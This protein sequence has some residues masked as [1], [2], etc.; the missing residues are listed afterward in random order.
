[1]KTSSKKK[2]IK[3]ILQ[4]LLIVVLCMVLI[5]GVCCYFLFS[6]IIS[7]VAEIEAQLESKI[8]NVE[9][10]TIYDRNGIVIGEVGMESREIV[11][12]EQ[13]PQVTIDAFLAIEDSRYFSHNGF[14]LPRFISSAVNNI[15]SGSFAQ[16][17]STLTM[18]TIDN[19]FIKPKEEEDALNGITYSTT[20]KLLSKLKEIYLAMRLDSKMSKEDIL[21]NYLNKINFGDSARGIQKGALYYFGKDVE[22]LNLSESAFLA[23]VIN[24]PYTNNPYRGYDET[25]GM[26]FYQYATN[27]RNTTLRQMLNHGYISQSEYDLATTTKLAFQLNGDDSDMANPYQAYIKAAMQEAFAL[28]G[29]DPATTPMEIYTALDTKAQDAVNKVMNKEAVTMPANDYFQVATTIIDNATGEVVAIGTGFDD[30]Y[31]TTYR[32]RANDERHQPGS[33]VKPFLDYALAFD[34]VGWASSKVVKDEKL[35]VYG[36][37]KHNYDYKYYGKVSVERAIAQSLNIPAFKALID[38]V[39]TV[40]YDPV[41]QYLLD[42]GFDSEVADKFDLLFGIGGAFFRVSPTQLAGAYSMLANYG[43]YREPHYVREVQ[44]KNEEKHF[45]SDHKTKQVL[46]KAAAW[47]T[48]DLLYKAITGE[49]QSYNWMS[50]SF[51][52]CGYPVYGKTGTTDWGDWTEQVGGGAQDG[53]MVNYTSEYTIATWT[54]FDGRIDGITYLSQDVQ[55]MNIPGVVNR[56][57]FDN[58]SKNPSRLQRPDGVSDFS[59]GYI[60]SEYLSQADK[61]NPETIL[62]YKDDL[63]PLQE[64]VEK[65]EKLKASDYTEGSFSKLQEVLKEATE[66]L[67]IKDGEDEPS[68]E[69]IDAMV[70]KLE[71]A[72]AQL[73]QLG[74]ASDYNALQAIIDRS[75]NIIDSNKYTSK[76]ENTLEDFINKAYNLMNQSVSKN[77]IDE[78]INEISNYLDTRTQYKKD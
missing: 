68:K 2:S 47:M 9:P 33:T 58:I 1:M 46:S 77:K 36:D 23:G 78:L 17:G 45:N 4:S 28:T 7:E 31:S 74:S 66:M 5:V 43:T 41:K 26:N 75:Q 8:F 54:G 72:Q 51:S 56:Y 30:P 61:L 44:Y 40:G 50:Y 53:W 13:I 34:K 38:V 6:T 14:D 32:D 52:G 3:S 76:F 10:T 55:N 49:H 69:T 65:I 62:N 70:Q 59:G 73:K 29:D 71:S 19:F 35:E 21:I 57:L 42:L 48:S 60:K 39:N 27:R 37:I 20:D 15:R 25:T 22:D 64:L 12:Y 16:G 18:Q 63:K 24:A 67:D 11:T